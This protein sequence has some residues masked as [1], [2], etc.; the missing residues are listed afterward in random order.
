MPL[1]L[2]DLDRLLKNDPKLVTLDLSKQPLDADDLD[3]LSTN[4]KHNTHLGRIKWPG[5]LP[6]DPISQQY[7]QA[8]Q[9]T[10]DQ[11]NKDF[12]AYPSHYQHA[13]LSTHVYKS[14]VIG[15]AVTLEEPQYNMTHKLLGWTVTEIFDLNRDN[16][17]Y[18]VLYV[19]QSAGHCVLAFR[20]TEPIPPEFTS[21]I[22]E[23]VAP[24]AAENLAYQERIKRWFSWGIHKAAVMT[25]QAHAG[26]RDLL[27]DLDLIAGRI[28]AQQ[29]DAY[30][31][32]IQAATYADDH[33]YRLSFTGHLLGGWLAQL[34][35]IHL[36][37][38]CRLD[39]NSPLRP[40]CAQLKVVTFDNPGIDTMV[41]AIQPTIEVSRQT[42]QETLDAFAKITTAYLTVPNPVNTCGQ[43]IWQSL[44]S[45]SRS[46]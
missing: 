20:G 9:K 42:W 43:T 36:L 30:Q 7:R 6:N 16:G 44:P 38:D 35:A 33:G 28:T 34:M 4:L 22:T 21:S 18:A 5:Y 17:L 29:I 40:T 15:Q 26:S 2:N 8:I 37:W 45:V 1:N 31:L 23:P 13:V 3:L 32:A 12:T 10:L 27:T 46:A 11:N 24:P 25:E 19:N 39:S 41:A 14:Q